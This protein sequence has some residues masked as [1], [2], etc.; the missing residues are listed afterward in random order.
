MPKSAWLSEALHGYIVAHSEPVDPV[1]RELGEE[2]SRVAGGLA[3][4][5]IAPEQGV[6]MELLVRVTGARRAVEVGTF[7]GHSSICIARALPADGRLLCLDTSEEW[8]A[9]A[10]RFWEKAGVANK[11]ELRLAP[12]AESLAQ[13]APDER[14]DFAFIDADK[15]GY[16]TYYE[17]ILSRMPAGGLIVC[18]NVLWG[19]SVA[20]PERR[21]ESTQAIRAFNAM[22]VD[23]ARVD[24]SMI[25]V[26][27]GLLLARKR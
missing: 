3:L 20:D 21:D 17:A 14:F 15:P 2:T 7:T 5:E 23:D 1:L 11:I 24:A 22:V 9:I 19:G 10:R 12:A 6:F 26:G 4:M 18:D 25:P 16:P 13:L 8:T 27:D